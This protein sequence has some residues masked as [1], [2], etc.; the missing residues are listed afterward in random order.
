MFDDF[1]FNDT[2]CKALL[3]IR[4]QSRWIK[5]PAPVSFGL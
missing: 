2:G 5:F 1:H 3:V 4:G